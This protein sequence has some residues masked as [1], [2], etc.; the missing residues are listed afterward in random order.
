MG[1]L[2]VWVGEAGVRLYSSGQPGG[3]RADRLLYQ[4]RLALGTVL[5]FLGSR[6]PSPVMGR[7][8]E[9]MRNDGPGDSNDR[10]TT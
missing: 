9:A 7:I 2:L 1:T 8:Q 10:K 6:L 5:S 4:A 3:A